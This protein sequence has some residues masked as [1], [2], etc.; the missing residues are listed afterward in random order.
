[1]EKNQFPF[2]MKVCIPSQRFLVSGHRIELK[3]YKETNIGSTNNNN[4]NNSNHFT[5]LTAE[6]AVVRVEFPEPRGTEQNLAHYLL[7]LLEV[8]FYISR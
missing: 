4:N 5:F 1:M 8:G 2:Q 3:N 7:R 6:Q